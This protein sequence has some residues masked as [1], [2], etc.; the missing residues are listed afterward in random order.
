[1]F[2]LRNLWTKTRALAA[3]GVD[4]FWRLLI[5]LPAAMLVGPRRRAMRVGLPVAFPAAVLGALPPVV[6]IPLISYELEWLA[7][8]CALLLLALGS[9]WVAAGG[10][11]GSEFAPL[12][13][14]S[15][16]VLLGSLGKRLIAVPAGRATLGGAVLAVLL[17][18][19]AR[20]ANP[21]TS[22]ALYRSEKP[23]TVDPALLERSAVRSSRFA[24]ALPQGWRTLEGAFIEPDTDG[25]Y[26][27]SPMTTDGDQ[28]VGPWV[29][30]RPGSYDL[31]TQG[32]SL[33]G[34][35]RVSVRK[36]DGTPLAEAPYSWRQMDVP[37][38]TFSA[39]F[40]LRTPTRIR[41]V[42][43]SWSSIRT[44]SSWILFRMNLRKEA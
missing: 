26:V 34:G 39:S 12:R 11:Y 4:R 35:F 13:R 28:L 23:A 42:V 20:P 21:G 18:A 38:E 1:V 14:V 19:L 41:A 31:V 9:L 8:W 17:L 15:D 25:L 43:S 33:V 44:A 16:P 29:E 36:R 3:D 40:V 37:K 7:A 2:V 27:R 24:R 5:L 6:T 30:L 22:D 10:R 32:R